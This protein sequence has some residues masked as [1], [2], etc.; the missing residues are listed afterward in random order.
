MVDDPLFEQHRSRGYHP[1]R[2]ERLLAGRRG[3]ARARA[4]GVTLRELPPRDASNA[5]LLRVHLPSYVAKIESLAGSVSALDNETYLA[6]STTG[7][8]HRAAGGAIMLVD[9]LLSASAGEPHQGI[10]LLRPPGHHATRTGGR[11]YCIFNNV[12]VAAGFACA[13]G[14]DRVA[15]VDFDVHHGNGTQDIFWADD[16]VLFISLHGASLYPGTGQVEEVGIGSGLGYT[17]NVPLPAASTFAAYEQAFETVVL[18]TLRGFAPKLVLASAGFDAHRRDPLGS[19]QLTGMSYRWI[20]R[21][22]RE[23]ADE[24]AGGRV[25]LVLEGGY[26]L[27]AVEASVYA[28]VVGVLGNA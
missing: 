25:G 1:E 17:R 7:V 9:A 5:D 27:T 12:A 8:A 16:R 28:S 11:G 13:N 24:S 23:V 6:P 21:R 20:C 2:P 26:D 19:M 22:L 4:A 14:I 3:L 15:I 18:P 10:A